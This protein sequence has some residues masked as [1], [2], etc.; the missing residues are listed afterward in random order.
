[1]SYLEIKSFIDEQIKALNAPL[2]IDENIKAIIGRHNLSED[3]IKG[4]LFKCNILIK[5]HNRNKF[6]KQVVHQIVQQVAKSEQE[7]LM[8]VNST[9]TR[10]STMLQPILLPD[11]VLAGSL[12]ERIKQLRELAEELPE[13][14]YLFALHTG[15]DEEEE[16]E[17]EP[18]P[19]EGLIQDDQEYVQTTSSIRKSYQK[20]VREELQGQIEVQKGRNEE[21]KTKYDHLRTKLLS[22]SSDL[23]Y[24]TQ[25]LR[26]LQT[27]NRKLGFLGLTQEELNDSDEEEEVPAIEEH[28]SLRA[29]LNRFGILV[30]KLD[31]AMG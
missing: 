29:Q 1:M 7:K 8:K 20:A 15:E 27:L 19:E 2:V 4:T 26:Y 14:S 16:S 18:T 21:L 10:L 30:E 9:L 23:T 17:D 24:K 5:R 31:F 28:G 25:K 6:N 3:K 13:L 12:D 11:F 22:V